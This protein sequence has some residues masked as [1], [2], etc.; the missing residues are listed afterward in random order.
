MGKNRYISRTNQQDTMAFFNFFRTPKPMRFEYKPKYW[1][2]EKA[3]LEKFKARLE[4]GQ[5]GDVEGAKT[6]ISEA[7]ARG[8]NK[9]LFAAERRKKSRQSNFIRFAIILLMAL[10]AYLAL[11]VYLPRTGLY[12]E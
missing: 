4:S 10:M 7:F 1:D 11:T 2:P 9:K 3:E 8:G 6:R 5:S 12:F